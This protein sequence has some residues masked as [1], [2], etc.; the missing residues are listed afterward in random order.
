MSKPALIP[1]EVSELAS[2]SVD[3]SASELFYIQNVDETRFEYGSD[4]FC[5][6]DDLIFR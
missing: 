5:Q 2:I 4:M 6:Y 1:Q 3:A